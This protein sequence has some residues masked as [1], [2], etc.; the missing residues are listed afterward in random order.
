M[1]FYLRKLGTVLLTSGFICLLN[2]TCIGDIDAVTKARHDLSLG[3][4]VNGKVA[5]IHC[6]P[7]DLVKT[8]QLLIELDDEEG[9]ALVQLYELRA[10][11]DLQMRSAE[12]A[13]RLAQV[14]EEAIRK[15]FENDAAKPI[16]VERAE[17]RTIQAELELSMAHQRGKEAIHQLKQA[18][19]RH[20]QYLL[21][22]PT[23][24]VVDQLTVEEGESVET[25]KPVLRLVVIDPL[26]VDAAVPIEKTLG[27]H[28]GDRAW[29]QPKLENQNEPILGKIIHLAQI[30]D[31]AS[32]TR[33]VRIEVPN[34]Q[35]LPAGGHVR[36]RFTPP[37]T[38]AA[39]K[40]IEI[41][42]IEAH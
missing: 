7:G 27:L 26:R 4:T 32:E 6:Q 41:K 9:E 31:A 30:A 29:I 40:D 42:L 38:S 37:A 33:L 19:A 2:S 13:M 18:T 28:S 34:S 23:N 17:I 25:L 20:Q 39:L 36:V 15:A 5:R 16:E 11:S 12:A 1:H 35:L 14:E 10:S 8:D 22:A 21:K 24:G 3:F